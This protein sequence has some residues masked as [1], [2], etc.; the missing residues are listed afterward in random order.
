MTP[1]ET[2]S[3]GSSGNTGG[4][5]GVTLPASS[6]APGLEG[7]EGGGGGGSGGNAWDSVPRAWAAE[8]HAHW[9]GVSP[10]VR[11]LIHRREA[12]VE[13]GIRQYADGHG[14]WSKLHGVFKD[15]AGDPNFKVD[16][17]YQALGQNHLALASEQDPAKRRQ[18]FVT[19]AKHYGVEFAEAAAGQPGAGAAGGA[20]PSAAVLE[21]I[22]TLVQPLFQRFQKM[23]QNE[24]TAKQ[25]AT[26]REVDAFFRDPK[27]K[28]VKEA[29]TLMAQLLNSRQASNVQ[30]AYDL[31][32]L[33]T[34]ELRAKYLAD[35]AEAASGGPGVEETPPAG[36]NL[37]SSAA[38]ASPGKSKTIDAT[39]AAVV[40]KHY[41]RTK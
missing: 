37:K 25:Q 26:E 23:D 35:L 1:E 20:D 19:M 38:P 7:S 36:P 33:R 3:F 24:A 4:I 5:A 18:M 27:N 21:K 31:A 32:V 40:Q 9:A 39:M 15:H 11:Q 8:Q 41:G 12:D 16:E 14:R 10:E 34:P 13:K 30:D 17:L 28:Y 2:S 29:G 6:G 22:T